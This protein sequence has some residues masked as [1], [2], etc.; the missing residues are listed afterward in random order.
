[1][2]QFYSDLLNNEFK[3]NIQRDPNYHKLSLF[4]I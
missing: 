3:Y 4:T 1:M 2:S